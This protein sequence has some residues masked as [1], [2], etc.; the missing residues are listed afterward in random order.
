[1]NGVST[2]KNLPLTWNENENIAWK[3]PLPAWGGATPVVWGDR[4]FIVSPSEVT[5]DQ[6]ASVGRKLPRSGRQHPGGS[7]LLLMCFKRSDGS[8]LWQQKIGTGNSLYGKQNMASPSPVTDGRHVWALTGTGIL[9]A[10]D[11]DGKRIWW[12]NLQA[13]YG[14]FSLVWGYA[15]SPLLY[16]GKLFVEV[17]HGATNDQAESFVVA[18]DGATA[19]V[20][21]KVNRITDA[22]KES[23]DAYT[24]PTLLHHNGSTQLI[25][26][27]AD[28]VTGHDLA[29]GKEIWRGG[30][31]NPDR[32]G[33]FRVCGSPVAVDGMVYATSRR[34]PLLAFRAGGQGDVTTSHLA[35]K[36]DEKDG[37]DVPSIASDR[38]FIYMVND[39]GIVTCLDGETGKV[40]WGPERTGVGTVSA[41]PV[42]ADGRVY[43]TNEN[44]VTTVLAAG[45]KLEILATNELDDG[46]TIASMAIA[47]SQIFLRTSSHLY[48]IA[49]E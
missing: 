17:L 21:W 1:M 29:T 27:G 31:L 20:V 39:K 37:T 8:L 2:A 42:V 45:P 34:K 11:M 36:Y 43:V 25:I 19:K 5:D 3:I 44:A 28:C 10:Y 6:E 33:N 4:V 24:T 38:K 49:K 23:P 46:Y 22:P 14:D 41:S 13:E 48:C 7:D 32:R 47:G 40:V 15:S 9:A 30:G 35:W 26:S 18:Y 16:N 12:H